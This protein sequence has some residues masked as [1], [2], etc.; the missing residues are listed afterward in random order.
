M[1]MKQENDKHSFVKRR[2]PNLHTQSYHHVV[3]E[4]QTQ[5]RPT[6]Q[7]MLSTDM[8]TQ[9]SHIIQ[10]QLKSTLVQLKDNDDDS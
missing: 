7:D 1:Y 3:T 8:C 10:A 5:C 6:L 4:A 2:R 9:Q